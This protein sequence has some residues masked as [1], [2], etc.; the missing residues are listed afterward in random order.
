MMGSVA[1]TSA[2]VARA[3]AATGPAGCEVAAVAG[4][5]G[6]ASGRGQ[7]PLGQRQV[8]GTGRGPTNLH[9]LFVPSPSYL[10]AY[11]R[12]GRVRAAFPWSVN[13]LSREKRNRKMLW[14]RTR[15]GSTT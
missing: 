13:R 14:G 12:A 10:P 11:S 4:E 6:H 2:A 8:L 7:R 1:A 15:A 5:A 3:L 9:D